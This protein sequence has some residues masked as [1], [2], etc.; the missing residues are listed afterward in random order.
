VAKEGVTFLTHQPGASSVALAGDFNGWHPRSA[1]LEQAGDDG[2]FETTLKLP[3]G[4]YRYRLVVDGRWTHDVRN[5]NVETNEFGE[6]N[7]IV[8]IG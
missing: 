7:S 5:P 3:P 4:R 6:L 8:E 1:R 2:D